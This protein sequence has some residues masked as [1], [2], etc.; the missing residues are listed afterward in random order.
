MCFTEII[1]AKIS[2]NIHS[3]GYPAFAVKNRIYRNVYISTTTVP[4]AT[5]LGKVV[6]YNEGLPPI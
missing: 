2:G 6:T 3:H 5:K 4:M 1:M